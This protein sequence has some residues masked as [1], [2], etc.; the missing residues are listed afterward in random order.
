MYLG[1]LVHCFQ[2]LEKSGIRY[3]DA[4]L[5]NMME[6]LDLVNIN[7]PTTPQSD[8]KLDLQRFQSICNESSSILDRVFQQ[9]LIIP[10]FIEFCEDISDIYEKVLVKIKLC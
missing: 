3:T 8:M 10:K 5:S 7:P 1:S 9:T 2:E 4:R 6:Q